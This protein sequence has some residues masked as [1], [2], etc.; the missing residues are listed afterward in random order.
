[1]GW[2]VFPVLPRGACLGFV[3]AA[4]EAVYVHRTA[5]EAEAIRLAGLLLGKW[6]ASRPER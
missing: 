5:D 6:R 4:S 3:D 2:R 1:M